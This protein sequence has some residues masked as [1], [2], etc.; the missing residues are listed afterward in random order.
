[1]SRVAVPCSFCSENIPPEDFERGKAVTLLKKHYCSKCMAA[2]VARSKQ[3]ET[4]PSSTF[5]TP[6]PVPIRT[7]GGRRRHERKECSMRVELSIYLPGG[8]LFDRGEA[9][10]WN[11]SLSGALLRALLLPRKSL[12]VE[13]H[14]IG[15]R[16]LEGPLQ[17]LEVQ[18]RPVRFVHSEDGLHL[19]I[20]FVK[21][22]EA[23]LRLL[24]NFV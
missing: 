10:L 8:R 18:G 24:R 12:P 16:V 2:A 13:P 21:T 4:S 20:E 22:Q 17:S 23:Q 11:I 5:Q 3:K 7:H 9:V 6:S 14:L 19:A 15:I 1:M